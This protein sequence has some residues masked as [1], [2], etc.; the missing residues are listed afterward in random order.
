M[1]KFIRLTQLEKLHSKCCFRHFT[2]LEPNKIPLKYIK[3]THR[4][5]SRAS[6][7]VQTLSEDL[8]LLCMCR[9]FR[10]VHKSVRQVLCILSQFYFVKFIP[11]HQR[12]ALDL[13][14]GNE[15]LLIICH[16]PA[17][18][19][20]LSFSSSL[21]LNFFAKLSQETTPLMHAKFIK[22]FWSG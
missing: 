22:R 8:Q 14:D 6:H 16:Q 5:D 10:G 19:L 12:Q 13:W 11:A 9:G 18:F 7:S 4:K 15:H 1:N 21:Q 20:W 3:V 17:V 2:K